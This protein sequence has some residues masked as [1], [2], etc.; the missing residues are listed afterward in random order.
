MTPSPRTFW[1]KIPIACIVLAAFTG[2]AQANPTWIDPPSSEPSIQAGHARGNPTEPGA[3]HQARKANPPTAS[4]MHSAEPGNVTASRPSALLR[5]GREPAHTARV[6][7][8]PAQQHQAARDLA[9][10]YLDLWSAPN[11]TALASAPSFY[12]P[13]VTFHGQARKISSVLAEKRRFAERWPEEAIVI[14]QRQPGFHA[15]PAEHTAWCG[16]SSTS[17]RQTCVKV[18][19]LWG[20]ESTNLL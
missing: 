1:K 3:A 2:V 17:L 20:L 19:G 13:T 16:R 12:G 14:A 11:F 10:A 9:F 5:S 7:N 6:S 18:D 4:F 8:P 15:H